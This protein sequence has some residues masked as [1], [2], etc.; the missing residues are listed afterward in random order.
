LACDFVGW[1]TL[2]ID[3][4]VPII[5]LIFLLFSF[6]SYKRFNYFF[7]KGAPKNPIR[8]TYI[9]N[10]NFESLTFLSTY[11]VPL[12]CFDLDFNLDEKRNILM[13]LLVL[14]LIG[15]IYIKTDL[16]YTNPTLSLLGYHIYR[17]DSLNAKKIVVIS[18]EKLNEGNWVYPKEI[19]DN[20][21]LVKKAQNDQATVT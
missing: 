17:I 10:L 21:H 18:R 12:L 8:I 11:I 1:K 16:F 5:S 4:I 9:E 7:V 13:F 19:S 15:A 20:V 3:N 14:T 2:I 6:W